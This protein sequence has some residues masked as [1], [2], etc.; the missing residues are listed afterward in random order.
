MRDPEWPGLYSEG[1]HKSVR[2]Y[3]FSKSCMSG[4]TTLVC[5]PSF[6][7]WHFAKSK[8][9]DSPQHHECF[10]KIHTTCLRGKA[11]KNI[12]FVIVSYLW[13]E[14]LSTAPKFDPRTSWKVGFA[15]TK[16]NLDEIIGKDEIALLVMFIFLNSRGNM[17][18]QIQSGSSRSLK[19]FQATCGSVIVAEIS[20]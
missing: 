14:T 10:S 15:P 20:A 5:K 1:K 16:E 13:T 9:F 19:S 8:H 2:F 18:H 3:I 17:L 7:I 12:I 11:S 4:S 6:N